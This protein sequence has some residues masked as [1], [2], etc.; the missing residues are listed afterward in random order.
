MNRNKAILLFIVLA[1]VAATAGI[2]SRYGRDQKLGRPG[3]K[4]QPL[5]DGRLEVV[6]PENVSDFTSQELKQNQVTLDTLPKDTSFG[7]RIY[8]SPDGLGIQLSV[9]LMGTDRTSLHKPQICFSGQG[10]SI[11]RTEVVEIPI[12]LP[13]PY[14]LPLIKLGLTRRADGAETNTGA[15][16]CLYWY[17]A[18]GVISADPSALRR[19][20]LSSKNLVRTGELQRWAYVLCYAPCPEGGEQKTFERMTTF[21]AEAVPQFQLHP[22]TPAR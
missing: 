11:D 9:V 14:D 21:L 15:A 2:L 4:T 16:V 3:V 5:P 8:Q 22:S 12:A 18:D 7:Q 10:F 13:Q 1:L 20:W 17:V 6:L 19:M